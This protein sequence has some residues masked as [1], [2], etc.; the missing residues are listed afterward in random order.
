MNQTGLK[1]EAILG[2]AALALAAHI[3][4]NQAVKAGANTG[5]LG[6]HLARR[7]NPKLNNSAL[8]SLKKGVINTSIPETPIIENEIRHFVSNPDFQKMPLKEK[9]RL[10]RILESRDLYGAVK[11]GAL[12]R[13]NPTWHTILSQLPDK[14][15]KEI[16]D[17]YKDSYIGKILSSFAKEVRKQKVLDPNIP[18]K[19][20]T[21]ELA[22]EALGNLGLIA[23]EPGVAL[24]NLTKRIGASD[25]KI[26]LLKKVPKASPQNV[27][28]INKAIDKTNKGV[29]FVRNEI[30]DVLSLHPLNTQAVKGMEEKP[31]GKLYNFVNTNLFNPIA[32]DVE[33]LGNK[34]GYHLKKENPV[35]AD[36]A[37]ERLKRMDAESKGW[38]RD[39]IDEAKIKAYQLKRDAEKKVDM[40]NRFMRMKMNGALNK[41][42]NIWSN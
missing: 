27:E 22:T 29:D 2:E 17:D 12:H 10:R 32:A 6:K 14:S 13:I 11:S 30:R 26:P 16:S 5:L 24:F 4:Q 1:K 38:T 7:F 18:S 35:A 15:L 36:I 31:M 40:Y 34:V 23:T 41:V 39:K 33:R 20:K 21:T 25:V 37:K 9:I 42:K 3:G 19:S 28:H 8:E